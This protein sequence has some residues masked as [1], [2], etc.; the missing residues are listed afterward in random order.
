ME[1][2]H[3]RSVNLD[4]MLCIVLSLEF[5][6]YRIYIYNYNYNLDKAITVETLENTFWGLVK[7]WKILF[8]ETTHSPSTL[9]CL[10]FLGWF[11]A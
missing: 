6:R 8:G 2:T 4:D 5:C 3:Q 7:L 1:G 9:V 10:G 11:N